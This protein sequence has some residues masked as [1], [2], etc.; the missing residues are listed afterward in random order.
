MTDEVE[1]FPLGAP[2]NRRDT[3][4]DLTPIP[5]RPNWFRDRKGREVYVEPPKPEKP[6]PTSPPT[7]P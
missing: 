4:H 3:T 7:V 6:A 2:T 5:D 1:R